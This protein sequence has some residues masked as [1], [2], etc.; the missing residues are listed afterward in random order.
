MP[1]KRKKTPKEQSKDWFVECLQRR[2]IEEV[3]YKRDVVDLF[4]NI[5][6]D[7]N[8]GLMRFSD[9]SSDDLENY[10]PTDL[11]I[12]LYDDNSSTFPASRSLVDMCEEQIT[13]FGFDRTPEDK[14]FSLESMEMWRDELLKCADKLTQVV[15]DNMD[16]I[17]EEL[18]ILG[19]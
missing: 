6:A 13:Y 8:L 19:E 16:A 4:E 10:F 15:N 2:K 11:K 18:E 14:L 5:I 17:K 3:V 1:D 7:K 9:T 12:A